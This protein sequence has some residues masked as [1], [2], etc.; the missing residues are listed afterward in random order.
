MLQ[1]IAMRVIVILLAMAMAAFSTGVFWV[2]VDL[3]LG[4]TITT[5]DALMVYWPIY[6]CL[7]WSLREDAKK[8]GLF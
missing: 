6:I 1:A 3:I 4:F 5:K 2:F 7:D 8:E